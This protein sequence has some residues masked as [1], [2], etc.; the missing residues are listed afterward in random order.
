MNW[1]NLLVAIGAVIQIAGLVMTVR[2]VQMVI[3]I[4]STVRC[5]LRDLVRR[6]RDEQLVDTRSVAV[7]MDLGW[8][9]DAELSIVGES[10]TE[11]LTR[12]LKE[13][14]QVVAELGRTVDALDRRMQRTVDARFAD[15][16]DELDAKE[17]RNAEFMWW[18]VF[19]I[20]F[21][22]IVQCLG[23]VL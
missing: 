9:V 7:Q 22:I 10:E 11:R 20:G 13:Q 23:S 4:W 18:G 2:Q 3:D 17:T 8:Y 14:K 12:E 16:A 6:I 21:G 19:L 1:A 5:Q 15:L